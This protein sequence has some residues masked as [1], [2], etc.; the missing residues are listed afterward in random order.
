MNEILEDRNQLLFHSYGIG[1]GKQ[2]EGD[3]SGLKAHIS[4]W[5]ERAGPR[6]R[7][8]GRV[9]FRP[10]A[11]FFLLVNLDQM[12]IRAYFEPLY[13]NNRTLPIP[14]ISISMLKS[15]PNYLIETMLEIIFSNI[16]P[17]SSDDHE[18]SGHA[19]MRAIDRSWDKLGHLL[20]WA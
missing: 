19:V 3:L 8:T 4:T 15:G 11:A 1:Q 16:G 17:D 13:E 10:D 12:I 6:I 20:G 14:E 9:R 2:R 7:S 5:I 18:I